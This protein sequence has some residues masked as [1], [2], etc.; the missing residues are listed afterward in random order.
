MTTY[1]NADEFFASKSNMLAA[2][3]LKGHEVNVEIESYDFK[4][5]NDG[6]TKMILTFKDREKKLSLNVTNGRA[7]R[8]G[9][10]ANFK[11]WIGKKILVYPTTTEYNNKTVPCVRVRMVPTEGFDDDIPF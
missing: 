6:E 10:G 11:D 1:E 2:E 4:T 5:F 3:D 7:I 9:L 8:S